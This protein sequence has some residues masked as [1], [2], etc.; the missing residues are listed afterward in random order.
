MNKVSIGELT[1]IGDRAVVHVAKI[2]GDFPTHIG[3]HVT[4][5]AG[6]LIHAATLQDA[7]VI[8]ES[9]QVLDGSVVESNCIVLPG[10]VV[11]PGTKVKSGELWGG[12]P[13]RK[14]RALT[15]EEI[16]NIVEQ[17][18]EKSQ[19]ANM[20]AIETS[21]SYAQILEEDE[22]AEIDQYLDEAQP[23]GTPVDAGDVLG[24]GAPGR[25]FRSTLS[26]PYDVKEPP[27]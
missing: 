17:A 3:N 9:T 11:T 13:A 12:S 24:Q 19:L 20:H 14:V 2:Q 1:S 6:A 22:L 16:A 4:I 5:G 7:V 25:I 21:K 18:I 10:S 23:K 27:K 15:D 8:G 26:H